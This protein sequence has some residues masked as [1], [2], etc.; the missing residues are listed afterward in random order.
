MI[1]TALM[2]VLGLV[3]LM[4]TRTKI[5]D[6]PGQVPGAVGRATLRGVSTL[7]LF[8]LLTAT[9]LPAVMCWALLA[10]GVLIASVLMVTG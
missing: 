9:L 8:D 5:R 1:A 4:S 10:A 2:T 3:L 7:A 6:A